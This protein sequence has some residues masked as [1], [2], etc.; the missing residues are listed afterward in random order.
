MSDTQQITV[1]AL[2]A[3]ATITATHTVHTKTIV[4]NHWVYLPLIQKQ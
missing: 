3:D 4:F 1:T 2:I